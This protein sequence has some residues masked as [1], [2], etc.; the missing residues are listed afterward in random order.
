M[1]IFTTIVTK[2]VMPRAPFDPSFR[3][4]HKPIIILS[5]LKEV[6]FFQT[7]AYPLFSEW[8]E[9]QKENN[10]KEFF[11]LIVVGKKKDSFSQKSKQKKDFHTKYQQNLLHLHTT[12]KCLERTKRPNKNLYLHL[13]DFMTKTKTYELTLMHT[14]D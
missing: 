9:S 5:T 1:Q 12:Q 4:Y 2:N 6:T 7:S 11:N 8:K 10:K 14:F 3:T 13:H